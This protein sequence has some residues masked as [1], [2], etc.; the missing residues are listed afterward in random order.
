MNIKGNPEMNTHF[1]PWR[2]AGL[3]CALALAAVAGPALQSSREAP[4][5]VSHSRISVHRDSNGMPKEGPR[6]EVETSN[7]SGYAIANFESNTSY[8]Q[9]RATW[10]VTEVSY[11]PPPP[12]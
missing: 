6:N 9:A 7:W 2:A 12:V 1:S 4:L 8:T 10:T 3:G 5:L 11:T